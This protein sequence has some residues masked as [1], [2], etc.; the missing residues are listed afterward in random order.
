MDHRFRLI[1]VACLTALLAA[2]G[3]SEPRSTLSTQSAKYAFGAEQVGSSQR[4]APYGGYAKGCLAGGVALPETGP[5]WQ[6]MRLSRNRNWGHPA[7]VDF[8]QDLSRKAAQQP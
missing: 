2:C 8:V 3:T 7:V 1:A 4:P 5:T 6:A